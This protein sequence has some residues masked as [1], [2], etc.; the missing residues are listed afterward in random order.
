MIYGTLSTLDTLAASQATIAQFGEDKAFQTVSDLLAAHNALLDDMLRSFVE[1]TEDR[2]RRYG[3]GSVGFMD[4]VDQFGRAD[5]SKMSQGVTVGFPLR[6]YEK[7]LQWTRDYF[8]VTTGAEFAAQINQAM[9]EDTA[10]VERG[11]KR[12]IF[13]STNSTFLDRYVD[14]VSLAVK[15]FV[16]ADSAEMPSGPNGESFNAATHTHYTFSAAWDLAAFTALVTNV[17][18][19]FG[20]GMVVVEINQAQEAATRAFTGFAPITDARIVSPTTATIAQG[21]LDLINF[22]NRMIGILGGAEVWVK[23]N[24]VPA[25]YEFAW[26]RGPADRPIAM[27]RRNAA[28]GALRLVADNENFPLRAQTREREVGFAVWNRVGGAVNFSNGG[29]YADPVF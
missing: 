22:N 26:M 27:R 19:H 28:R 25:N 21:S 12:A 15:A 1:V 24:R 4:E 10:T 7:S 18:E 14:N 17:T 2:Q 3:G 9:L 29:A 20:T 13:G 16:N 6:K 5:A 11:I 8:E 23:S